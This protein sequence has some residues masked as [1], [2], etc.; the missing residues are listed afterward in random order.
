[1][2][3]FTILIKDKFAFFANKYELRDGMVLVAT[4]EDG[5]NIEGG[6]SIGEAFYMG[7][8]ASIL[9]IIGGILISISSF[10]IYGPV[11][12]VQTVLLSITGDCGYPKYS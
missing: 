10:K 2:V 6:P 8:F 5:I 11:K 4:S 1:M 7:W 3:V 12:G 9:N